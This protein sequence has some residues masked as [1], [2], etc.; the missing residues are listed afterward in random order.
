MPVKIAFQ[1]GF[2]LLSA[3]CLCVAA[4][5]RQADAQR[6]YEQGLRYER[7]GQPEKAWD[8]FSRSITAGPTA[9]AYL[10]R[11]KAKLALK[12]QDKAL[13]DLAETIRLDPKNLEALHLRAET[14]AN[15]G[16]HRNALN[17]FARLIE[18]GAG[19]SA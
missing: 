1:V 9:N 2:W 3:A 8:S 15:L 19:T 18:L 12:V 17:D 4:D 14:Y 10:H 11:A 5:P 13:G 6:E 7:A 16:Q